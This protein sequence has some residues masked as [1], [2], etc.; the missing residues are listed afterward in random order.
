MP[1][2]SAA[3]AATTAFILMLASSPVYAGTITDCP[4]KKDITCDHGVGKYKYDD[5]ANAFHKS[6]TNE[7]NGAMARSKC[8]GCGS[9]LV[10]TANA[11]GLDDTT[12]CY[13]TNIQD[14]SGEDQALVAAVYDDSK[15]YAWCSAY[16]MVVASTASW[17]LNSSPRHAPS[18]RPPV[19]PRQLS[20]ARQSSFADLCLR[21]C[22]VYAV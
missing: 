2:K 10:V 22:R 5:V 16:R 13:Y 9:K 14:A 15:G 11:G 17:G 7:I 4:F 6:S 21:T 19:H 12:N 3:F 1:S 18:L 20:L 8:A